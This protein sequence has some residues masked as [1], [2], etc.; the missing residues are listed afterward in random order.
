M[1]HLSDTGG[2][3]PLASYFEERFHG[4]TEIH[5][6]QHTR[7]SIRD[8]RIDTLA[9]LDRIYTNMFPADLEDTRPYAAATHLL[10]DPSFP[11]DHIPV[12]A[13]LQ[14]VFTRPPGRPRIPP[15]V[16][17]HPQFSEMT[18]L[19]LLDAGIASHGAGIGSLEAL[20]DILHLA[21]RQIKRGVAAVDPQCVHV[22]LHWGLV[23]LRGA[24]AHD[25]E[26]CRRAVVAFPSLA[27][28]FDST[29]CTLLPTF[30]ELLQDLANNDIQAMLHSMEVD[31]ERPEWK[32]VGMKE[33]LRR[34]SSAWATKR[35]MTSSFAVLD[36]HGVAA[37]D[38]G[39]ASR[40]LRSHWEPVFRAPRICQEAQCRILSY[41][42]VAPPH[43]QWDITNDDIDYVLEHCHDS[44]PGPDGIPYSAWSKAHP[45][46][47]ALFRAAYRD[48]ELGALPPPGFNHSTMVFIPKGELE[49]DVIQ[50]QRAPEAMRPITLSNTDAKLVAAILNNKLS[51]LASITVI[52][53]QRGFVRGRG[54]VD[55]IIETEALA[56]HLCRH[57]AEESGMVLFDFVSA[58]PSLSHDFIFAALHQVGVPPDMIRLIHVLY[59]D[60]VTSISLGGAE[61]ES[62]LIR[63]GIKQGCPASGSI[64]A[65]ALD[66]FV[67]KLCLMLPKPL[68][69]VVAFADDL[70]IVARRILA[71]LKVLQP[72]FEDLAL[73]SGLRL[74]TGKSLIVPVGRTTAFAV[75][76][77]L[78]DSLPQ[79]AGMRIDSKG[80]LLGVFVGPAA[81]A[82]RWT[83]TGDKF[84]RRARDA[85]ASGG[86]FWLAL[87][88][89]R[90]FA[91]SVLGHLAQFAQLPVSLLRM[92]E[93][94]VQG[95][96]RGPH[97]VFSVRSLCYLKDL[98]CP[99]EAPQLQHI[100]RASLVRAATSSQE[101]FRARDRFNSDDLPD[102]ALLHPRSVSWFSDSCFAAMLEAYESVTAI[103]IHLE[104]LP[105]A[106]FQAEL[107]NQLRARTSPGPWPALL[108]RRLL[109]WLPGFAPADV[110]IVL[111]NLREA[112]ARLPAPL[113]LSAL[114]V[115]LN[116]LCTAARL[117]GAESPCLLCGWPAGDCVEHLVHC[118]SL[119]SFVQS[120][121]PAIF[122]HQGPALRHRVLCFAVP[123][124]STHLLGDVVVF[125]D[126]VYF[127]HNSRRHCSNGPSPA[128]L[129]T[130]RLRQL[131]LRHVSL[132]KSRSHA[133]RG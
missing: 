117:Q 86:G 24:R 35:K 38:L 106:S 131:E 6:G 12:R 103:P 47:K 74:H 3:D 57:F 95:L 49:Q 33:T 1:A 93:L 113:V 34:R 23:L 15:W 129:A 126:V 8:G 29:S 101:F 122:R 50:V 77:F 87:Q 109:R 31:T 69:T 63:A 64:F 16:T 123:S 124:M 28:H 27:A 4:F 30:H 62:F 39:H 80:K 94:A 20:K 10:T 25:R 72:A 112:F 5:Q 7:K 32:K 89:Y 22:Q 61:G 66:P 48:L 90:I 53:Q 92:E 97:N 40:L 127:I 54:M 120:S 58:F 83:T 75:R 42:A 107:V 52:G 70:A 41:A 81:S 13:V 104:A 119:V 130:A 67:R 76:R 105:T 133:A 44:A 111:A 59:T 17:A 45:D 73:A 121:C 36:S 26:A 56:L 128:E 100:N 110:H 116:G 9:R 78:V 37:A 46:I 84:W 99:L 14:P 88:R 96:S 11:S 102:D 19:T 79:W 98:G 65:L 21:A 118:A 91:V 51:Q 108:Q 71:A 55:N 132:R 85:K 125:C 43:F 82:C 114:R 115:V 60:C 2:D 18:R 68:N